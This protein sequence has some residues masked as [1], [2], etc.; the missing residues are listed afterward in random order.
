R[1]RGGGVTLADLQIRRGDNGVRDLFVAARAAGG[2]VLAIPAVVSGPVPCAHL[3]SDEPTGGAVGAVA[4]HGHRLSEAR[5]A[6]AGG[7]FRVVQAEGDRPRRTGAVR[8]RRRVIEGREKGAARR[9]RRGD[10]CRSRFRDGYG[11]R[12]ESPILVP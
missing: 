4:S 12:R 2:V 9:V 10:E 7:L 11:R 5:G 8:Q 3:V 6:G 1:P